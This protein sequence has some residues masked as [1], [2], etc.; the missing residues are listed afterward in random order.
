MNAP[1]WFYKTARTP[2]AGYIGADAARVW[3]R[4]RFLYAV[5]YVL[6]VPLGLTAC[7]WAEVSGLGILWV[8]AAV[9]WVGASPLAARSI[10]T[11]S[12]ANRIASAHLSGTRGYRMAVSCPIT[13]WGWQWVRAIT[14][15]DDEHAA[16]VRMGQT[17]GADI[18]IEQLV[19]RKRQA[20]RLTRVALSLT[21][22]LGGFVVGVVLAFAAGQTKSLGVFLVFIGASAAAFGLPHAFR[23]RFT[24]AVTFYRGD[25]TQELSISKA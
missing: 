1:N 5:A 8:V 17:V 12:E 19:E 11:A 3:V 4:S 6:A 20:Q 16:H 2:I 13:S 21:G 23:A 22:F 18:A 14:R 9:S 10:I 24:R 25:V 7:L 15:A